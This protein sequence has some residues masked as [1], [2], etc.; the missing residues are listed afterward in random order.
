MSDLLSRRDLLKRGGVIAIGLTAPRWL[1]TIAQADVVRQAAGGK[2]AGDTVLVVC[3]LSG[4]NDGLNTVVPYANKRYY[5]LR[6]TLGLAEEKILKITDDLGFHPALGGLADLYRQGKVAVIQNVGYP[7]PNRSHFESMAIWQSASRER[8]LKHGWIGRHLD[9]VNPSNPVVSLGLSTEK[10]LALTAQRA[11]VP[12]F[13]SLADLQSMVGDPDVE[14]MLREIQGVDAEQGTSTRLVQQA[15]RSALDAMSSLTKQL[16]T[17]TPQ[18]TYA[19]DPFG[20]GFRQIAHLIA[21]SPAT[22]VVYF[23]AG[24]FDT[25]A[26]QAD[27]HERL[28]RGFAN[29]IQTFQGEMEAIGRADKVVVLVFS[30]FGRRVSENNSQGTDHGAAA[31]MFLVGS[32]VK[33]GFHG[34]L[35]NLDD[36]RD[37]DLKHSIDF[38]EVYAAALDE[39]MGGDSA[40]VLGEHFQP[41]PVFR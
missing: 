28:L 25:H 33:G 1:S 22:R 29:A 19:N 16:Q 12:C 23:S 26:R 5:A 11:S 27:T 38:R 13:A 36:L 30:E 10:P 20:N 9:H 39:W 41:L 40:V 7:R 3:Q 2:A 15:N 32:R 6:P 24:G 31:P 21:A 35:P 18:G 17:Y 14:R 37:G 4:G 34:P 8:S